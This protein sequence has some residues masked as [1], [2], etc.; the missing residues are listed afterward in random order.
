MSFRNTETVLVRSLLL[1]L[2]LSSSV[3][4]ATAEDTPDLYRVDRQKTMR[5]SLVPVSLLLK[6]T[7]IYVVD[8]DTI[9]V[10]IVGRHPPLVSR[11]TVGLLG[12]DSPE[13]DGKEPYGRESAGYARKR[14][15]GKTVF[16]A[17]DRTLRDR[18]GRI[19]CYVYFADGSLFNAQIISD[20]YAYA[21]VRYRFQF[22]KEFVALEKAARTGKL[23]LWKR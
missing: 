23:G 20:G 6:A 13:L 15:D 10:S 7:V 17:F 22:L 16:L 5:Y 21:Y 8:G 9:K 3:S 12:I 2:L 19:L 14:L 4:P 18:Y 11:E 1:F